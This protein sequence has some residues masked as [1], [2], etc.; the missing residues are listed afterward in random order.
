M[1]ALF[2]PHIY[3]VHNA[4]KWTVNV[5]GLKRVFLYGTRVLPDKTRYLTVIGTGQSH[6]SEC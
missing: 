4:N 1:A 5:E 3:S 6:L 2:C